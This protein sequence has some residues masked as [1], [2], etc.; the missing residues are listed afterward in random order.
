MYKHGRVDQNHSDIVLVL[1]KLGWLVHDT[2]SQGNG[3]PDLVCCYKGKV[4]LIE[5]KFARAKLTPDQNKFKAAGWPFHV[6]RTVDDVL[7]LMAAHA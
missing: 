3:F 2:S 7:N 5:I 4:M 6:V 1:K